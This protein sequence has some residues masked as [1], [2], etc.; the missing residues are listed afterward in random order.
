[1]LTPAQSRSAA[2]ACAAA[3]TGGA[4]GG[5]NTEHGFASDLILR[6]R[7]TSSVAA[8]YAEAAVWGRSRGV[9]AQS[10]ATAALATATRYMSTDHRHAPSKHSTVAAQIRDDDPRCL[11]TFDVAIAGYRT[12]NVPADALFTNHTELHIPLRRMECIVHEDTLARL[13]KWDDRALTKADR[14]QTEDLTCTR[15]VL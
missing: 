5:E 6:G 12:L 10:G 1:M 7:A 8:L 13:I 14:G 9:A 11:P 3:V 2:A 4:D 15:P